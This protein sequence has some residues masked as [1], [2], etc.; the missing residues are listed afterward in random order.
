LRITNHSIR[1]Q[2]AARISSNVMP[3]KMKY[4]LTIQLEASNEGEYDLL[5]QV[6]DKIENLLG[7]AHEVDGHDFGS[8]EMN[9]FIL[10]NNPNEAFELLKNYLVTKFNNVLKVAYRELE[11]EKYYVLWPK[12]FIGEFEVK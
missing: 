1:R 6:E 4:Q 11:G 10:T 9:I 2:K 3:N 12:G 8:G 7:T 5:I